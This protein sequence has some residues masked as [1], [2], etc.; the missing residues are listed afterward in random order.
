MYGIMYTCDHFFSLWLVVFSE[1]VLLFFWNWG[2][3]GGSRKIK[4]CFGAES[5]RCFCLNFRAYLHLVSMRKKKTGLYPPLRW[6][7]NL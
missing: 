5:R 6:V 7:Y 4:R 3:M 1:N 2:K